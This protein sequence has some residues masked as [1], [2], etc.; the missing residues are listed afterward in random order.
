MAHENKIFFNLLNEAKK[1]AEERAKAIVKKGMGRYRDLIKNK[2]Q[3]TTYLAVSHNPEDLNSDH[4]YTSLIHDSSPGI[5]HLARQLKLIPNIRAEELYTSLGRKS[6]SK[7]VYSPAVFSRIPRERHIGDESAKSNARKDSGIYIP[8]P[9]HPDYSAF[10]AEALCHFPIRQGSR[11]RKNET[12]ESLSLFGFHTALQRAGYKRINHRDPSRSKPGEYY[13]GKGKNGTDF[14]AHTHEDENGVSHKVGDDPEKPFDVKFVN[15]SSS[16]NRKNLAM[17]SL[18]RQKEKGLAFPSMR[19]ALKLIDPSGKMEVLSR[20]NNE[21]EEQRLEKARKEAETKLTSEIQ[22][23]QKK[24]IEKKS[25]RIVNY[26]I[27]N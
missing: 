16:T 23:R 26:A 5:L 25:I 14:Y 12:K 1:T 4:G 22:T 8:H 13:I 18:F 2:R 24:R 11:N 7:E 19:T 15:P 27:S 21:T 6:H 10:E 3:G 17:V 20:K 9:K